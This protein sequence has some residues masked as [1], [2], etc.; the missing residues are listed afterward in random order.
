[1]PNFFLL[2]NQLTV[3]FIMEVQESFRDENREV[4]RVLADQVGAKIVPMS[5]LYELWSEGKMPKLNENLLI[6]ASRVKRHTPS[7]DW[8]ELQIQVEFEERP[9]HLLV[10]TLAEQQE[11]D[12]LGKPDQVAIQQIL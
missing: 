9:G 3:F 2:I 5:M 4:Q 12:P 10:Q 6:L 11:I 7:R 1:M 8:E